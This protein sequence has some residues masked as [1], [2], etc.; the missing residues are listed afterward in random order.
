MPEH[1]LDYLGT[2]A[3]RR[4]PDWGRSPTGRSG[5]GPPLLLIT[6]YSG[7]MESWDPRFVDTLAQHHRVVLIDNAGIGKTRPCRP[8]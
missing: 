3:G 6:G 5:N 8:R 1:R 7:T 2:G 4:A